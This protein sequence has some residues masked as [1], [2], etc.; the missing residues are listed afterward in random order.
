MNYLRI[1]HFG[2]NEKGINYT[3][4][5]IY[6]VNGGDDTEKIVPEIKD[7]F[8][9]R[10]EEVSKS[11]RIQNTRFND[12]RSFFIE[13]FEKLFDNVDNFDTYSKKI[14][15]KF[16]VNLK[17]VKRKNFILVIFDT[18]IEYDNCLVILTMEA[19]GGVQLEDDDLKIIS[20]LLPDSAAKIKKA[21]I[22]FEKESLIFKNGDEEKLDDDSDELPVRHAVVIDSRGLDDNITLSFAQF[23]DSTNIPD[24]P[25]A[26]ARILTDV[27]P[28]N[29][30][31]VLKDGVKKGDVKDEI[32]IMFSKRRSSNFRE[33]T[34]ALVN[35]FVSEQK[36]E[37]AKLDIEKLSDKIFRAARRKNSAINMKFDAEIARVPK[38]V[39]KDNQGGKNINIS[40]S[41]S[42]LTDKDVEYDPDTESGKYIL[43]IN[44]SAVKLTEI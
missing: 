9:G 8:E 19:S 41:E 29:L 44:K 21:V 10:A 38:K 14:A 16:Y 12:P 23:L 31:S 5:K 18:Q 2:T 20:E 28:K 26:V 17:N 1:F 15:H 6:T 24:K 7:Y 32:K 13:Y 25:S 30:K 39:F 27:F 37:E 40:I 34:E 11:K 22:V 36:M 35:K 3:S 42:S 33:L 43:K 4:G